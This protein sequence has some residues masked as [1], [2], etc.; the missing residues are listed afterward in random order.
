MSSSLMPMEAEDKS[1]LAHDSI[2]TGELL[3]QKSITPMMIVDSGRVIIKANQQ[4]CELFG[5]TLEEVTGRKTSVLTPSDAHFQQYSEAFEKTLE[6][7]VE[8]SE[9]LYKKSDGTLFW[10]KLTGIPLETELGSFV[11]WSFDDIT[12]EVDAREKLKRSHKELEAIF[13]RTNVGLMYVVDGVIQKVNS[14]M[15]SILGEEKN[16]QNLDIESVLG[17][18]GTCKQES[19]KKIKRFQK[20][21]GDS[22]LTEREIVK[23]D[24]GCYLIVFSDITVHIQEKENLTKLAETDGLTKIYNRRAFTDIA[25]QVI[26]ENKTESVSFVMLDIDYFKQVN[27]TWGHDIGDDVLVE[28]TML[29]QKLLRRGEII[30]RVGGEEFAILLFLDKK[31]AAIVCERIRQAVEENEFTKEKLKIT[32]SMGMVNSTDLS[33]SDFDAVYKAADLKLYEAKRIGRNRL[34]Y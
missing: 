23:I 8:S 7:S 6:G 5:Y 22:I 25:R 20:K 14:T 2:L 10:V 16:I 24:E 17:C 30:G 13:E 4:F 32:V 12:A 21:N 19:S 26:K 34:V 11:L 29:T 9:L 18:F 3:F 31:E 1:G 15:L 33:T 27:D 28:L